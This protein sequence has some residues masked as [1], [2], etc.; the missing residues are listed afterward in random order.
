MND[1]D[2]AASPPGA[3]KRIRIVQLAAATLRALAD[4]DLA[5]ANRASP[6]PLG[7]AFVDPDWRR[8]WQYRSTQVA[9]DPSAAAWVT[10]V[11]WDDE[12]HVA[13]GRAGFHAPPDPR[14]MVEVGYA[15]DPVHRRQGYAR[16]TLEA[17][18][19]RAS[20]EPAVG[21]VRASVGLANTASRR[22]IEQYGFAVVGEQWDD[23]DGLE[24]IFEVAAR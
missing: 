1:R 13:V 17:L 9:A 2:Q 10:G 22:L 8:T 5:A 18:L 15:V 20:R 7:P 19:E 24:T 14:G 3:A 6:V 21:V 4:G 23:E 12:Q 16:A 11:I